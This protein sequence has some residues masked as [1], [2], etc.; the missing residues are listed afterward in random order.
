M[1]ALCS[2]TVM[3]TCVVFVDIAGQSSPLSPFFKEII[4]A[5]LATAQ[6]QG[7]QEGQK[8]QISSFEAINDMVRTQAQNLKSKPEGAAS[9]CSQSLWKL[10]SLLWVWYTAC[11]HVGAEHAMPPCLT[12]DGTLIL[13]ASLPNEA[14]M[15]VV[16][17]AVAGQGMCSE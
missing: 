8:L 14:I 15:G 12:I 10:R 2:G 17:P 6:R 3:L 13:S 9:C 5:L 11:R 7:G 1:L 4:S 16:V